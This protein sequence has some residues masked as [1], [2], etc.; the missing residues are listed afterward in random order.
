VVPANCTVLLYG[1]LMPGEVRSSVLSGFATGWE[2]A[3]ATGT[4]WDTARG[5][6]AATFND[7]KSIPGVLVSIRQERWAEA[8]RLLD[9]I[10]AEGCCIAR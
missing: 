9:E 4:L 5:F 1:T 7:D 6:P 2:D 8:L 10:T 3:S